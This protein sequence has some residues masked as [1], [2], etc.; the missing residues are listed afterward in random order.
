[1]EYGNTVE[2]EYLVR[3]N[4]LIP[5]ASFRRQNGK[6]IVIE[7]GTT[8]ANKIITYMAN[9]DIEEIR[10][11]DKK[12]ILAGKWTCWDGSWVLNPINANESEKR[13]AALIVR[14]EQLNEKLKH[15][16]RKFQSMIDCSD[17]CFV[18]CSSC[19]TLVHI[20]QVHC[21]NYGAKEILVCKK[22][23]APAANV[24]LLPQ[25]WETYQVIQRERYGEVSEEAIRRYE[26]MFKGR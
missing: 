16:I 26:Q 19:L 14:Y 7:I 21:A 5:D 25:L 4:N 11:Y 8:Q 6:A 20:D 3:F 1:M 10:W 23:E 9:E 2:R 17:H 18:L 15:E 24:G 12:A 22:C 13:Y